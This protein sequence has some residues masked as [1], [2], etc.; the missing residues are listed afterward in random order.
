M[1]RDIKPANFL[2]G[3]NTHEDKVSLLF[4]VYNLYH[5][6]KLSPLQHFYNSL[7]VAKILFD[8]Y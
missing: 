8:F 4:N 5:C 3:R 7:G 1:H 6:I 2:M